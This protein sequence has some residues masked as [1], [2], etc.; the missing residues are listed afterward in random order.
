MPRLQC[1][2]KFAECGGAVVDSKTFDRHKRHDLS[3]HLQ[4]AIATANMACK[5]QNDDIVGHL[6]S[7]SLSR[8]TS[9]A[10]TLSQPTTPSLRFSGKS[11]GQK[12]VDK[13]LCQLRDIET[14]L[15][16][17]IASVHEKLGRIGIPLAPNDAFPLLFAM[18]T[19]RTIRTQLSGITS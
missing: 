5:S 19:A 1:F 4:D 14:L 17:L 11:T 15:E 16:D 3:K 8:P 18:S 2:C 10:P 7:L 12:L 6:A 13:S 9:P